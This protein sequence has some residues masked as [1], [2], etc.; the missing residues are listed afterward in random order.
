[1]SGSLSEE[2]IQL[3][4]EYTFRENCVAYAA[5]ALLLYHVSLNLTHVL[6]C[7]WE[8]RSIANLLSIVNWLAIVG[9]AIT[10]IVPLPMDNIPR[11][12]AVTNVYFTVYLVN[13][14]MLPLVAALRV[15]ALSG[16]NWYCVLPVWFLGM[17]PVCTTVWFMIQE[18]F[19]II[20]QLGCMSSLPISSA[21]YSAIVIT[22]RASVVVS[23]ALVI[24]VTWYYISRTSLLRTQLT[25]EIWTTRPNITTV[26]LRDGTLYFLV[27]SLLNTLDLIVD[28]VTI[29]GGNQGIN[30]TDFIL[31]MSSIL[32]SQ[33]LI[34]IR[35]ASERSTRVLS[36]QSLSF[37]DSQQASDPQLAWIA[38]ADFAADIVHGPARD[39]D[40][41]IVSDFEDNDDPQGENE[42]GLVGINV[43]DVP[44][45]GEQ[46]D[47][48]ILSP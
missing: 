38:S 5:V 47:T 21:N 14:A 24:A 32:V 4:L 29:R 22:S 36:S 19:V 20:P 46:T 7:L 28:V 23:D 35:E 27:I 31:P 37:I 30:I 26:M 13:A 43:E 9:T 11:C 45:A 10:N 16:R 40:D 42:A 41:D 17:V 3:N 25:R 18:A 8:R 48:E 2:I 44:V 15:H 1:M 12:A 33:F 6:R 39:G 34:C